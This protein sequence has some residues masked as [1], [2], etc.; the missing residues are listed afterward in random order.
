MSKA[1]KVQVKLLRL[2][3]RVNRRT[4]KSDTDLTS[5]VESLI[6]GY[7]SGNGDAVLYDGLIEINGDECFMDEATVENIT[8][9]PTSN[10]NSNMIYILNTA[11]FIHNRHPVDNSTCYIV[12]TLPEV[13]EPATDV[14]QSFVK[15]YYNSSDNTV[16]GYL[17][18]PLAA[19]FSSLAGTTIVAGWYPASQLLPL[20][21][22]SYTGVITNISDDTNDSTIRLLLG[23]K[24][25]I[26]QNGWIELTNTDLDERFPVVT[27]LGHWVQ[28]VQNRE[29]KQPEYVALPISHSANDAAKYQIPLREDGRIQ[30]QRPIV[31][32]DAAN[33]EYVDEQIQE[34]SYGNPVHKYHTTNFHYYN[35]EI[36]QG[37]A[38]IGLHRN[39][40]DSKSEHIPLRGSNGLM[41]CNVPEDATNNAVVNKGYVNNLIK[42]LT[43]RIAALEAKL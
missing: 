43:D 1:K 14:K 24:V 11:T 18:G 33:K 21:G 2:I 41:T 38:S 37:N 39:A 35:S 6:A 3:Q 13:G 40:E 12:E 7:G 34:Y 10:I 20:A 8:E 23:T 36:D 5:G 17:D 42:S 19:A 27:E 9:L 29:G 32:R 16:Y 22:W 15:A 28:T 26:Y 31:S 4:G 30:T 25:Y